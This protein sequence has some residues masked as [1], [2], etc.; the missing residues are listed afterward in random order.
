MPI[1]DCKTDIH[2]ISE[3]QLKVV[4]FSLRHA[5]AFL[6]NICS[7]DTIIIGHA[8]HN[9]FKA[10]R[11]DHRNV[12]DTAYLY[13]IENEPG[14]S[15]SIRDI[16][17]QALGVKLPDIHDSVLDSRASLQAAIYA[18]AHDDIAPI[19]RANSIAHSLLVHRLPDYCTAEH[20]TDMLIAQTQI[21][22]VRVEF[23]V[24]KGEP[25]ASSKKCNVHF[26]TVQHAD[27]AFES[28][29]GPNRPDNK[30]RP[31]KRVYLSSG[32]YVWIRR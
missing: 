25:V 4:S 2:G 18:M 14:A 29:G 6:M 31:Q 27:L 13:S 10:L 17:D 26:L 5:Q 8:V 12:I 1:S 20:I 22:P 23:L 3:D 9:D 7:S 16:S 24:A 30:Q 32:G 21:V 11:F 15:A 28:I 19:I